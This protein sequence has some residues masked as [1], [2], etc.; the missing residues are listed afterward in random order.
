MGGKVGCI[1][2]KVRI[3][4]GHEALGEIC[5]AGSRWVG[6]KM[7]REARTLTTCLLILHVH[8]FIDETS[9]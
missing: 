4:L 3:L 2:R 9:S 5:R 6:R 8:E 1:A 7:G